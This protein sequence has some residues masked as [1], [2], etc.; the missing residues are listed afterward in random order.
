MSREAQFNFIGE[1][2][3]SNTK[4]GSRRTPLVS[5]NVKHRIIEFNKAYVDDRNVDGKLIKF[6]VDTDKKAIAWKFFEKGSLDDLKQYRLIKIRKSGN[7][8]FSIT[9]ILSTLKL[10]KENYKHIE[11]KEYKYTGGTLEGV[12]KYDYVTIR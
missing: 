2:L 4:V 6:Y 11:P 8:R 5:I 12:I 1:N 9:G 3:L 10:P 7:M